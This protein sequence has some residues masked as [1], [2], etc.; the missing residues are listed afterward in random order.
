ML[1]TP[2]GRW[3]AWYAAMAGAA[4]I[5]LQNSGCR[6]IISSRKVRRGFLRCHE[7]A[8]AWGEVSAC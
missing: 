2:P 1:D 6:R 4:V 8:H 7:A 3:S 5:Y